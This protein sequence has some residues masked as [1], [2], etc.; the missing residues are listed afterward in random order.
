MINKTQRNFGWEL[1]HRIDFAKNLRIGNK[2]SSTKA[3]EG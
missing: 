1:S 3:L 2:S